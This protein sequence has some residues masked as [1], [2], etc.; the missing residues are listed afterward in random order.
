MKRTFTMNRISYAKE[1]YKNIFKLQCTYDY[2]TCIIVISDVKINTSFPYNFS[3]KNKLH[4][5]YCMADIRLSDYGQF[6]NFDINSDIQKT[7][8][9]TFLLDCL[10]E[11]I[12]IHKKTYEYD[13][14]IKY[15]KG[16]ISTALKYDWDISIPFYFNYL[17]RMNIETKN[18]FVTINRHLYYKEN[19]NSKVEVNCVND[20]INQGKDGIIKYEIIY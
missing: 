18:K 9:G 13:Y 14:K 3:T 1:H 11:L 17:N 12:L 15:V 5:T 19:W 20:F 16:S 8:I 4:N 7:G 10:F 2:N 6:I